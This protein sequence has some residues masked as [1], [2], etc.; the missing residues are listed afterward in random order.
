M[1]IRLRM[2]LPTYATKGTSRNSLFLHT[3]KLDY[4]N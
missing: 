3:N 1:G 2:L 4:E